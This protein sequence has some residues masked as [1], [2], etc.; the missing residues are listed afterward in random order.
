MK[1]Q[2]E[3]GN[4]TAG[5]V[6]SGKRFTSEAGLNARGTLA[7]ING[8]YT[9]TV[10]F[11]DIQYSNTYIKLP[12]TVSVDRI[13]RANTS[14]F[15][16]MAKASSFG[17]AT[18]ADVADGKTFTSDAGLRV[19]GTMKA[20][21]T[22]TVTTDYDLICAFVTERGIVVD[23]RNAGTYSDMLVGQIAT[24]SSRVSGPPSVTGSGSYIGLT[25][26][27]RAQIQMLGDV[28]IREPGGGGG[29]N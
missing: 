8:E 9:T 5:D 20:N 4:A 13:I 26:V 27:G 29:G 17:D 25:D 10:G 22:C 14:K 15:T 7:E 6:A 1:S 21:E 24:T 3:F 16:C 12:G 28:V 18:A 19:T 2:S 11:N 23:I